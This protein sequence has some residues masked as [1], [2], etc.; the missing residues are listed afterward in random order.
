[1]LDQLIHALVQSKN[2]AADDV[3]VE[4]LHLGD[5]QEKYPVLEATGG[6]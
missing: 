5:A 6:A 4:A 3:L 1:M 2:E